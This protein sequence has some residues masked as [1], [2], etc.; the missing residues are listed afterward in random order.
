MSRSMDAFLLKPK[1]DCQTDKVLRCL[2]LYFLFVLRHCDSRWRRERGALAARE[3][4]GYTDESPRRP[5]GLARA[6]PP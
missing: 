4:G 6:P 2:W 1:D 3:F 5:L